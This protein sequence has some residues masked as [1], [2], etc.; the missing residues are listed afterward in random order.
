MQSS[1]LRGSIVFQLDVATNGCQAPFHNDDDSDSESS[2][3]EPPPSNWNEL[4]II[5][6]V[7]LNSG[8]M[9]E[10]DLEK[11]FV[12]IALAFRCD[13]YTLKQRLQADEHARNL[14][15]ENVLLELSRGRETLEVLK[16]LCLDSKRSKIL[17][18]LELSLDILTGTVERI[19]NTA[20]VLG[21]VHQEARVI[22]AVELMVAH[23]ENV[24]RRLE[25]HEAVLE[26]AKKMIQQQNSCRSIDDTGAPL[27][28]S[29]FLL[30]FL[31]AF[32]VF[33][34]SGFV[35]PLDLDESDSWKKSFQQN[36]S[37]RRVSMSLIPSDIQP[38]QK[39]KRESKKR[40]AR[41]E[42]DPSHKLFPACSSP[43][44]SSASSCSAI[45]KDDSCSVDG[46][47]FDLDEVSAPAPQWGPPPQPSPIPECSV[48]CKATAGGKVPHK[49]C[50]PD[51]RQRYKSKASLAKKKADKEKKKSNICQRISVDGSSCRQ[52]RQACRRSLLL[53]VF[54]FL[55]FITWM[56]LFV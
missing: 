29:S 20:E 16:G 39:A 33:D 3:E 13:Q 22:R 6:R 5:D 49:S 14:A 41:E 47:P 23:V 55:S 32:P 17:Q 44:L 37:R 21:A 38:F 40:A 48:P 28:L 4:S 8:E 1:A 15:E 36:G 54:V 9:S 12:Q 18:R 51:K 50:A 45:N 52:R 11:N 43:C 19:S 56:F 53:C 24:R 10:T 34:L 2:R 30:T 7:G 42:A 26:E 46:R 31:F 27:G 35:S 25:R